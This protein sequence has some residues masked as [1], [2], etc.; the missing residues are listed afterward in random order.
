VGKDKVARWTEMKSF[1]NVIEPYIG[2]VKEADHP[3]KG[4][5]NP[6]IFR[7]SNPLVLEL[8]CGKGEYTVGLAAKYPEKNFIGVDIKGARI[9]RGAKTAF[10]NN[11]KNASFLRTRIEFIKSFFSASEVSEIWITFPDPFPKQRMSGRRLT[12]PQF[13]NLYSGIL[14]DGGIIHLKTDNT[15]LYQYTRELVMAN[16][17]EI[18]TDNDDLHR[19]GNTDEIL[20]IRTHYENLFLREGIK[21]K[22]ISFRLPKNKKIE[23]AYH[24]K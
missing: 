6:E 1:G 15:Q 14:C 19:E 13:L 18:I 10:E 2:D 3:V 8:G 20:S 22:Y 17:L 5:W 9:W 21:I 24:K 12:S 4:K 16:R 11:I 23:D 7:N